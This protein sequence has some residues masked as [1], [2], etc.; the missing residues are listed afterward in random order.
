MS[1]QD[2]GKRLAALESRVTELKEEV[3]S[4]R[5]GRQKDWRRAV[6]NMPVTRICRAFL[7]KP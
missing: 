4:A 2:L 5:S 6:E 3:R 7:R 1:R